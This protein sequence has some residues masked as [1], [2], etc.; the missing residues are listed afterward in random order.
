MAKSKK[1]S[2]EEQ[3]AAF[4]SLLEHPL[5]DEINAVR[6]IIKNTDAAI[7]ERIK[8]NAPSYYAH[9]VDLVTFHVRPQDKVHLV[10]HHIAI[11]QVKSALLEGDYK[12]RRMMYLKNME[13][14]RTHQEELQRIMQA[15]INLVTS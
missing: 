12:D 7:F 4:M 10:F 1:P 6:Q 2:D 3:V 14:I 11:V 5:K 15:Y 8:W 9:G 13:A